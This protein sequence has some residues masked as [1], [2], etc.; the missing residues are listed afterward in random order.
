MAKNWKRVEGIGSGDVYIE[1]NDIREI[2]EI[3]PPTTVVDENGEERPRA[4]VIVVKGPK[5]G[6]LRISLPK[7]Y[8]D[9]IESDVESGSLTTGMGVDCI[10]WKRLFDKDGKPV[11][12]SEGRPRKT[13][14]PD[15]QRPN[16]YK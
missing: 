6:S 2:V 4:A 12:D 3:V 11:L 16:F 5:G 13:F 9:D 7:Q 15:G 14:Y 10:G 1:A 8:W